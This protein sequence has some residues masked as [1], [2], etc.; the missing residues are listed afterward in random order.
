MRKRA[1]HSLVRQAS[2]C[3][4]ILAMAFVG[5][6]IGAPAAIP[7]AHGQTISNIVGDALGLAVIAGVI[8]L[9]TRDS[10]G[11]YYRYPYGT[12]SNGVYVYNGPYYVMYPAYQGSYYGG[13]VPGAWYWNGRECFGAALTTPAC[14]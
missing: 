11:V 7:P 8:Y 3:L 9:I 5:F 13:P 4:L 14:D 1:C 6:N 12:Y 10:N 2:M